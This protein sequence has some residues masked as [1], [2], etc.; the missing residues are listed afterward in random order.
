MLSSKTNKPLCSVFKVINSVS[1]RCVCVYLDMNKAGFGRVYSGC[2]FRGLFW[3]FGSSVSKH[4]LRWKWWKHLL[5]F[6]SDD[7]GELQQGMEQ[8][9]T[10]S[11]SSDQS[12]NLVL[13]C[14]VFCFVRFKCKENKIQI[15][16]DSL[17]TFYVIHMLILVCWSVL[18]FVFFNPKK[19]DT[20]RQCQ[21]LRVFSNVIRQIR[22]HPVPRRKKTDSTRR[23][24]PQI[25]K[26]KAKVFIRNDLVTLG[27]FCRKYLNHKSPNSLPHLNP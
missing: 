5:V 17:G 26:N 2:P 8:Q 3:Q 16:L 9:I 23:V 10:K 12:E 13:L 21:R 24:R 20:R 6:P 27:H 15:N 14:S 11:G 4:R 22:L 19:K 18:R 25:R 7:M 1:S